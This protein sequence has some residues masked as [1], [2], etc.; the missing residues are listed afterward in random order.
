LITPAASENILEGITRDSIIELARRELHLEVVER[1]VDR[2]EL[3]ISDEIFFTGTAVEVAPVVRV[4]HRPVANAEVGPVTSELRHLYVEA[5]S[6]RLD[7]YRHWLT[8]VYGAER[9]AGAR[10]AEIPEEYL[11]GV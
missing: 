4:D 9:E 1:A 7:F 2:S 8:P 6:G 3:Y 5:T 10:L 11:W